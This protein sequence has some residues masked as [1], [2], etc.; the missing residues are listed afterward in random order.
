MNGCGSQ[1]HTIAAAKVKKRQ[2]VSKV[3]V[4]RDVVPIAQKSADPQTFHLL[5]CEEIAHMIIPTSTFNH[6]KSIT[7]ID[8]WQI[9]TH[10][11]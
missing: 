10:C 9:V 6:L 11:A 2:V 5:G 4:P 8:D 7:K 1:G 3:G